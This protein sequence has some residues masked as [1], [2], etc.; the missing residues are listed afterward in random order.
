MF[1]QLVV[2]GLSALSVV[3]AGPTLAPTSAEHNVNLAPAQNHT[4]VSSTTPPGLYKVS[5]SLALGNTKN[6][7]VK[8]SPP[9]G[10]WP[11][12]TRSDVSPTWWVDQ[13]SNNKFNLSYN[14]LGVLRVPA[15]VLEPP[16]GEPGS[17]QVVATRG[18]SLLATW[19]VESAGV[20]QWIIKVPDVDLVWTTNSDSTISLEKANGT[21]AQRWNF[22]LQ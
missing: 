9:L 22:Q 19:S 11:L 20:N 1:S 5:Q 17:S 18:V 21:P 10:P 8:L 15:A 7:A 16:T 12:S 6:L 13:V 3:C 14:F 4:I 2:L